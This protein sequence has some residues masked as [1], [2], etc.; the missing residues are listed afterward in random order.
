MRPRGSR[1]WPISSQ[2]PTATAAGVRISMDVR[3]RVFDNVLVERLWRT[4]KYEEIYL[5]DYASVLELEQGLQSYF[6]FYNHE[7]LHQSLGYRTPAEVHVG[8]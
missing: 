4:V 5:K 6:L 1:R 7:R 3:G 8:S 2:W